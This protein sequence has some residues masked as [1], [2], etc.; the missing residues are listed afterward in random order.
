MCPADS[1]PAITMSRLRKLDVRKDGHQVLTVPRKRAHSDTATISAVTSHGPK[2]RPEA[3]QPAAADHQRYRCRRSMAVE[4]GFEPTEE[5]PLHTLSRRAPSATRRLHRSRAYLSVAIGGRLRYRPAYGA[6]RRTR[7]AAQ[8]TR[9]RGRRRAPR[10]AGPAAG[11]A[12]RPRPIRRHRPADRGPRTPAGRSVP[13]S[14]APAHIVHGSSV[15]TSVQSSSRQLPSR[16]A[17]S[18]QGHDL[19][20][21]SRDRRWPRADCGRG[22]SRRQPASSTTAPDRHV[23]HRRGSRRR[24]SA[25]AC[26]IAGSKLAR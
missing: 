20:V 8:R 11:R 24:A 3:R 21:R 1:L 13:A 17:R 5:L 15:T 4:V 10:P 12:A 26:R 23:G 9:P 2:L 6:R 25:M 16:L 18:A 7:A 22:R 14:S 19:G